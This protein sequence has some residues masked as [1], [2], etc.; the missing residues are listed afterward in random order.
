MHVLYLVMCSTGFDKSTHPFVGNLLLIRDSFHKSPKGVSVR[1]HFPARPC[2]L[3]SPRSPDSFVEMEP[4]TG[5]T[6]QSPGNETSSV[7]LDV[8]NRFREIN[9]SEN[10][11]Q[12]CGVYKRTEFTV[13]SLLALTIHQQ[14]V[15]SEGRT[16]TNRYF[17][18]DRREELPM[19]L[20]FQPKL[21]AWF[22]LGG[23][24]NWMMW[25]TA[26]K[27]ESFDRI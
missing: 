25:S 12:P 9:P 16:L 24:M 14:S 18:E 23:K 11:L 7:S 26:F 1:S 20:K 10:P 21:S 22:L 2:P 17:W 13:L 27:A 8:W 4:S 15:Q 5:I 19:S 3:G 6:G